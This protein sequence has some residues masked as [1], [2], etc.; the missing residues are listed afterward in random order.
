MN[1]MYDAIK[2]KNQLLLDDLILHLG[3]L[4]PLL[5]DCKI[6]SGM[7]KVMFIYIQIWY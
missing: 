4:F 5:Y 6:Q 2:D 3:D 1:L 7:Q